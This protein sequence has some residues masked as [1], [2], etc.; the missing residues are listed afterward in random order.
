MSPRCVSQRR[1]THRRWKH[2]DQTRNLFSNACQQRWDTVGIDWVRNGRV[3][4]IQLVK[5]RQISVTSP[6]IP[7]PLVNLR[8]RNGSSELTSR[9]FNGLT[10]TATATC[11]CDESIS[12]MDEKMRCGITEKMPP[13]FETQVTN[14]GGILTCRL[15]DNIHYH[16]F[17]LR[18]QKSHVRIFPSRGYFVKFGL[19]NNCFCFSLLSHM[20]CLPYV[21]V[22]GI[23]LLQLVRFLLQYEKLWEA[24]LYIRFTNGY[25]TKRM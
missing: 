7:I 5:T 14:F 9:T 25:V 21:C 15:R 11:S 3:I 10:R 19:F 6:A 1:C 24:A 16:P 22:D 2:R 13:E 23:T 17:R 8:V 20:Y 12:I 4:C 18:G